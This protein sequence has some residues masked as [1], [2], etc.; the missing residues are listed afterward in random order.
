MKQ[1]KRYYKGKK[2]NELK[3][4]YIIMKEGKETKYLKS[5]IGRVDCHC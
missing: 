3:S 2:I 1:E 4:Q 5:Y